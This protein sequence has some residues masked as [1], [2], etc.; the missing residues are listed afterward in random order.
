[1]LGHTSQCLAG[2]ID[3]KQPAQKA[4][5]MYAAEI[6]A[7]GAAVCWSFG[8]LLAT[9]PVR[10]MGAVPFNR[11]RMALVFLML[12]C[13]ALVSGGWTS[14]TWA[15]TGTLMAS[16]FIGIFC[17]DTAFYACLRR[18]GPR[19]TG[20]LFA[21]NA[22]LAAILGFI[23]L[24]ETLTGLTVLGIALVMAGVVM[25]VFFGTTTQRH[26]FEQVRGP[27]WA[28]VGLGL[29]SALC[30]AVGTIVVR[31]AMATGIDPVAASALRVGLA[32]VLL[33]SLRFL[34]VPLFKATAKVD[35]RLLGQVALSG[36]VGMGL[37]MTCLL[38]GLAHGPA[39]VVATLSAT[40]PVLILPVLWI[41]TRERPATGAW[42]GAGI[43]VCGAACIFNA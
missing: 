24:G 28:G 30:Q 40:S 23:V 5:F 31:P 11:L 43:A 37:G 18:L 19:R 8:G 20:I 32:A 33:S 36:L 3:A 25:A 38:F 42:L 35:L 7:L 21:T 29:F 17:G 41:A 39:G 26:S 16:A 1:M 12:A 34:P 9:V 2:R 22:P 4:T 27:L 10:A 13:A 15:T 6:A 14:L